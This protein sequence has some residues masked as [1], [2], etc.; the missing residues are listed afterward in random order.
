MVDDKPLPF[1]TTASHKQWGAFP[2]TPLWKRSYL[3]RHYGLA[4]ID[5]AVGNQTVPLMAQWR[6]DGHPADM[7]E[8]VGTL[9]ARFGV[10]RLEA[11]F[12]PG[13][14]GDGDRQTPT[15]QCFPYRRVNGAWPYLAKDVERDPTLSRISLRNTLSQ[16]AQPPVS[17]GRERVGLSLIMALAAVTSVPARGVPAMVTVFRTEDGARVGTMGPARWLALTLA[18]SFL[19]QRTL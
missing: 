13:Y 7:T 8:Q 15:D 2:A 5:V 17:T 1:E 19:R 18:D 10:N 4:T 12:K 9:L 3:A 16:S 6:C 11:G 14:T